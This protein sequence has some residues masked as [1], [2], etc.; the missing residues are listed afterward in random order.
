MV[1]AMNPSL[2]HEL[3][4]SITNLY[5]RSNGEQHLIV[6]SESERL[7]VGASGR[8]HLGAVARIEV[9]DLDVPPGNANLGVPLGHHVSII[10]E[11]DRAD[12]GRRRFWPPPDD[13]WAIDRVGAAVV[14]LE[15]PEDWSVALFDRRRR[16]DSGVADDADGGLHAVQVA[17]GASD[18]RYRDRAELNLSLL[19]TGNGGKDSS[20][21]D[22][23]AVDG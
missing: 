20:A 14:K 11:E 15:L 4:G 21:A 2:L 23:A 1:R 12:T 3:K 5:V 8:K 7:L 9:D 10:I 19:G 22:G 18:S 13:V 16:I 6:W 17:L